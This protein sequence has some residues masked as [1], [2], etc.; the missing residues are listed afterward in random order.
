MP[1]IFVD[2]SAWIALLNANDVLHKQAQ[3]IMGDLRR[4]KVRLITTEFVL[5]HP[6]MTSS[7]LALSN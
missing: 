2:T 4:K 5:P 3:Q 6:I 7:K 1:S